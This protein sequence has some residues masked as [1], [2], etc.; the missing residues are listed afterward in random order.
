VIYLLRHAHAGT[1]AAWPGPDDERPLTDLGRSEA[2]AVAD[3][4]AAR[5]ITR[6]LSSAYVRCLQSV[7]RLS[8]LTGLPVE[9]E[10]AL[11]EGADPALTAALLAGTDP[12]TVACSHGDVISAFLGRAAAEGADLEGGL[13]FRKASVWHLERSPTGRIVS[14]RYD[15][16][17]IIEI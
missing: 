15:P 6:I 17:P 8:E 14:G 4:L 2:A 16:P 3:R 9:I 10:S 7:E 11:K 1:R 5:G 12:G 13:R